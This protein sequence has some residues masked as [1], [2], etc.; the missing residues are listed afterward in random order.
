MWSRR[1]LKKMFTKG[2][3]KVAVFERKRM[4]CSV[5]AGKIYTSYF[6]AN[7]IDCVTL[8]GKAIFSFSE[9]VDNILVFLGKV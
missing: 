7:S 8:T 9:F 3:Q 6:M 1:V 2:R 5:T 4:H